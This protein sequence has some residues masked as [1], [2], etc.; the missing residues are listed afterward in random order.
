MNAADAKPRCMSSQ[1]ERETRA[2][3]EQQ[4]CHQNITTRVCLMRRESFRVCRG[5]EQQA[6]AAPPLC[7]RVLIESRTS[8]S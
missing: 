1:R 6:R 3:A 2:V 8:V 7:L 5:G 4:R